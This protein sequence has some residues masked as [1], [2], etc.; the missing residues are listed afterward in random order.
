[1][2]DLLDRI[3]EKIEFT[4]DGCWTWTAFTDRGYGKV[5]GGDGKTYKAHRALY[6]LVVGPIPED[7]QLDH[8]CRNRACVN[9]DHLEP[10]TY[11]EN[12]RRGVEAKTHCIHGHLYD[13]ENTYRRPD[14]TRLCRVCMRRHALAGYYRSKA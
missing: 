14:G 1:M 3:A 10:V 7:L 2:A 12:R 8:L 4:D 6:Q 9:P 13:A 5:N 11:A